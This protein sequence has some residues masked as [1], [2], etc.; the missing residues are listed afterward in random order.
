MNLTGPFN[1]DRAGIRAL[2]VIKYQCDADEAS[3]ESP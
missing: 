1:L 3:I 2:V